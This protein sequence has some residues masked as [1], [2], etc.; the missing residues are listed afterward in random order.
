MENA[1]NSKKSFD[2]F[3]SFEKILL[4]ITG[5]ADEN[6]L[7]LSTDEK[8]DII[9]ITN[10]LTIE[11]KRSYSNYFRR[12]NNLNNRKKIND[13]LKEIE[14]NDENNDEKKKEKKKTKLLAYVLYKL[15]NESLTEITK[16]ILH[17]NGNLFSQEFLQ[18]LG[19]SVP[20][21][22]K[23]FEMASFKLTDEQ[24]MI[25]SDLDNIKETKDLEKMDNIKN[26]KTTLNFNLG[27]LTPLFIIIDKERSEI[28]DANKKPVFK[29]L[30]ENFIELVKNNSNLY[31]KNQSLIK[32]PQFKELSENEKKERIIEDM[33]NYKPGDKDIYYYSL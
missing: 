17:N 15:C 28:V 20:D 11:L 23:K 14:V 13:K 25:M 2:K 5:R 16:P 26:C 1:T 24:A 3:F 31:L 32:V 7:N 4:F 29:N 18:Y 19:T 33:I 8:Q 27:M 30:V 6:A 10:L 9:N 12:I 21:L 22:K